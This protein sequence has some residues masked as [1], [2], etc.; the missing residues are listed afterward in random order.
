MRH[1]SPIYWCGLLALG[2]AF[3][4][5]AASSP[6]SQPFRQSYALSPR[7]RIQIE[8]RYGNV[9]ISGWDRPEVRIEAVRSAPGANILVDASNDRLAV[10]T[11]Y[12][13]AEP[14]NPASVEYRITMPRTAD[15]EEVRLFNGGL[16]IRGVAGAVKATT[17]N[18]S[19]K[20]EGLQGKADLETINGKVEAGFARVSGSQPISLRSV[21][22]R[23]VLSIPPH[24]GGQLIAQNR[25]G[26]IETDF[27]SPAPTPNGHHLQAVLGNGGPRILLHNVNGGISIHSSWSRRRVRPDL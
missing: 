12:A 8:N 18:G 11:Q 15:L 14:E 26:G 1:S 25:A 6:A 23:I 16:S 22:G 5:P 10:R 9:Q 27:D 7:G 19:I 20:A 4:L 13:G 2:G 17:V 3:L 21:N 24:A